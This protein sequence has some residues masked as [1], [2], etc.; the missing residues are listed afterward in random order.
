MMSAAFDVALYCFWEASDLLPLRAW[1]EL[2]IG[3]ILHSANAVLAR[4]VWI[5]GVALYAPGHS[6]VVF[7][8]G[9]QVD[10]W[11]VPVRT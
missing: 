4:L 11:N 9:L 7:L 3:C 5:G 2:L 6:Q 1:C 8:F 10:N